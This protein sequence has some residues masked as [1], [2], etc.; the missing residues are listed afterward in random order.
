MLFPAN[1]LLQFLLAHLIYIFADIQVHEVHLATIWAILRPFH[2]VMHCVF[3]LNRQQLLIVF[4]YPELV[5]RA[6]ELFGVLLFEK[7]L[8]VGNYQ[9]LE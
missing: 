7:V 6:Y 5:C 8:R 9:G 1:G 4:L 2:L 3:G